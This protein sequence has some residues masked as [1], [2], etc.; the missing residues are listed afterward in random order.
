[1]IAGNPEQKE[2]RTLFMSVWHAIY[3]NKLIQ[4]IKS[5]SVRKEKL[6]QRIL[7]LILII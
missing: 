5:V 6:Y 3:S 7:F 2:D 4:K 1:M